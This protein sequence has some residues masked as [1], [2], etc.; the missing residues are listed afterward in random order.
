LDETFDFS[1]PFSLGVS[2]GLV[3]ALVIVSLHVYKRFGG[4]IATGGDSND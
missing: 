3:L 2:H 4:M 1:V